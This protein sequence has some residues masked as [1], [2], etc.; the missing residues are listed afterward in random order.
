MPI[1]HYEAA[2]SAATAGRATIEVGT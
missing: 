2:G 1:E